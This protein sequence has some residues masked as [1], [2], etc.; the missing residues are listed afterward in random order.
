MP[1]AGLARVAYLLELLS[2]NLK[3]KIATRVPVADWYPL[4]Q[5]NMVVTRSQTRVTLMRLPW[6]LIL[7]CTD[8]MDDRTFVCAVGIALGATEP[9]DAVRSGAI[10]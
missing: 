3:R 7:L 5:A 1:R 4:G 10:H 6:H 9:L 2:V 8:Q